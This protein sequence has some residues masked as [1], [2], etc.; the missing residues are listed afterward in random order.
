MANGKGEPEKVKYK[1]VGRVELKR[2]GEKNRRGVKELSYA[3]KGGKKR[4]TRMLGIS[5][6][7]KCQRK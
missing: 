7:L 4:K 6:H 5:L 3:L 2:S 1:M